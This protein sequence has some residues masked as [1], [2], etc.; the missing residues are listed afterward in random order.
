MQ[1]MRQVLVLILVVA[2]ACVATPEA[3]RTPQIAAGVH[4]GSLALGGLTAEPA[5]TAIEAAVAK[6]VPVVLG[7]TTL[8]AWPDTLRLR[9]PVEGTVSAALTAN[10]NTALT[11]PARW[12]QPRLDGFV[13]QVA[14]AFNRAPTPAQFVAIVKKRPV[15]AEARPGVAVDRDALERA[16][17][18]ALRTGDRAP[19]TVPTE[20]IRAKR[21][22]ATFGSI[23]WVDRGTNTL[24]LYRSTKLVKVLRV[25]TGRAEYPTPSGS[26]HIV[27]MQE[28]PW[29]IPPASPWAQGAKPIPPG[30]GNPLGTR[31][32]GLDAAGVGMHGT[33][34][35]ASI[36]Y[37][38][39]HGCIRMHIS[40]AEWLFG[41][42]A[43]GTPVYIT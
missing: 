20:R 26:W 5:R 29:W 2:L 9:A 11:L 41:H 36:G 33:P 24:R 4:L 16:L 1:S 39:S 13:A 32:M 43:V 10:T 6:P 40:D 27:T 22:R 18:D 25:A 34:D 8:Y 31:W 14:H 19:L 7:D 38:A 35:A 23:V 15:I 42:V 30:P 37:S 28:N 21:T 17:V 3:A 12:S